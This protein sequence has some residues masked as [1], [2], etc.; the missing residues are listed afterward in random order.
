MG[1][2]RSLLSLQVNRGL[3]TSVVIIFQARCSYN[4]VELIATGRLC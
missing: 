1:T 3:R 4:V 2:K